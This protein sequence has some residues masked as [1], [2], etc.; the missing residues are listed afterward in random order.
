MRKSIVI[1]LIASS[2]LFADQYNV[3]VGSFDTNSPIEPI[4]AYKNKA[5]ESIGGIKNVESI[6]SGIFTG[7]SKYRAVVARTN[8]IS[9]ADV[10]ALVSEIRAAGYKDAYFVEQQKSGFVADGE[11]VAL[12][13]NQ[14]SSADVAVA[15]VAEPV[16]SLSEEKPTQE[17]SSPSVENQLTLAQ[18]VKSV[19]EE[20]PNLKQ[21]EYAYLQ[22]GKDLN[23]ANNAYYPTLD[24]SGTYGYE[25]K[26]Q[27]YGY[28][29]STKNTKTKGDGMKTTA[30]ATLVENIYTGGADKNR[31]ISQSHRLD[32]A[33][34]SVAQKADR[35]VLALVDAYLEVISQKK[36]LDIATEN[37][38]THEEIYSQIKE[39]TDTGFARSSEE[40]QA[41]SRL[42]L[43]QSN[44]IAQENNFNDALSTFEKLYGKRIDAN[45]LVMPSFDIVLP[46]S[47][48][49]VFDK[50]MQ[51]NPSVRIEDSNIKMA[52]SV[53]NEKDAPFRPKLDFEA[54]ANYSKDNVFYDE[55]NEKTY[56]VLLRV[57]Y[58]LYNKG[59]DKLEKEK[60]KLAVNES[61]SSMESIKRDLAESLKFS[62]QTYTLDEKK[63]EYL[64]RHVDYSKE[65]LDSYRDEF[66]IGRRDLI[67]LL[68]AESEYNNALEEQVKT[69]KTFLYAKYRLLDNMGMITDSFDPGFAKRYIQG[70]CSIQEDLR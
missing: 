10:K 12:S 67:N 57:R 2:F 30:N 50:A 48:S 22:V 47:E 29:D 9:L 68:D 62:W 69:Q 40:R 53:S 3:F 11:S 64:A 70:A 23:I 46:S 19:L 37:V 7:S 28:T 6:A 42:T 63:L 54:T 58:N 39:R 21:S 18:A 59:I 1:S 16:M 55:Y 51:C 32:A 49:S 27:K 24:I 41:G 66:R 44:L 15:P 17:T 52:E 25:A 5:Q 35:L 8:D 45:T 61:V 38:K 60:S 26:G 14:S 4:E 34:F 43:A 31:I 36:L 13:E 65:T 33:A 20:N 56:D